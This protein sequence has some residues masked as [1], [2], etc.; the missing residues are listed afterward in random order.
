[1]QQL[2]Y[3]N[4]ASKGVGEELSLKD[5][6]SSTLL[7]LDDVT[8]QRDQYLRILQAAEQACNHYL[9]DISRLELKNKKLKRRFK[10]AQK[11]VRKIESFALVRAS[12]RLCLFV[13]K[14]KR[15]AIRRFK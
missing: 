12:L 7:L 8:Q 3:T 6:L 4:E 5:D 14:Y 9:R 13:R 11:K 2:D 10:K 15:A 1:M